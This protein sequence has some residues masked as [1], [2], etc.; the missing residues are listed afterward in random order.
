MSAPFMGCIPSWTRVINQAKDALKN[1]TDVDGL[2]YVALR[3]EK[4][5]ETQD[6]GP[7]N[8]G[9]IIADLRSTLALVNAAK[10]GSPLTD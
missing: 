7:G 2:G 3:L 9:Y 10:G 4:E 6:D 8:R 5:I 1:P